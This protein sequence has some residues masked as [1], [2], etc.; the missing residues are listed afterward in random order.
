M[1]GQYF[2]QMQQ[3]AVFNLVSFQ[4]VGEH[5]VHFTVILLF[6]VQQ[7]LY[8]FAVE[9]SLKPKSNALLHGKYTV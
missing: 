9:N 3:H 2:V 5:H 4:F 7:I 6:F 8:R 1:I